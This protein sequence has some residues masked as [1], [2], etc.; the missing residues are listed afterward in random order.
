MFCRSYTY[1]YLIIDALFLANINYLSSK[2]L[3]NARLKVT[4]AA[5]MLNV[6]IMKEASVASV[7]MDIQAMALCV[8]VKAF[9]KY[10]PNRQI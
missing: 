9:V 10:T 8:Q 5:T 2:M 1:I 3:T 4:L 6:S 7:S